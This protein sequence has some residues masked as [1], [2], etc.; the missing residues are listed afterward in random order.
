MF[1]YIIYVYIRIH[2]LGKKWPEKLQHP[3]HPVF[4]QDW[5]PAPNQPNHRVHDTGDVPKVRGFGV[6]GATAQ[7][8]ADQ[9]YW[10]ELGT[11]KKTTCR[12]GKIPLERECKVY[13]YLYT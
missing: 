11:G 13:I 1:I 5:G 8:F 10:E 2:I 12:R 4:S 3:L 6:C 9:P 7:K